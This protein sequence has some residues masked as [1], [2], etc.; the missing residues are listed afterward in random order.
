MVDSIIHANGTDFPNN[1]L[2]RLNLT[3]SSVQLNNYGSA[4]N[5]FLKAELD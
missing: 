1:I 3:S 2:L 4:G 5:I